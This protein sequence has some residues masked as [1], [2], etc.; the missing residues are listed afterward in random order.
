M[1]SEFQSTSDD[2][3]EQA[4]AGSGESLGQLLQLY[5]NYLKLVVMGQMEF[6]VMPSGP[7]WSVVTVTTLGPA[8]VATRCATA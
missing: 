8:L 7:S 2:L 1:T 6:A 3:L 4:K 5:S